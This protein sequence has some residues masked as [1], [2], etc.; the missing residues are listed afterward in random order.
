[1]KFRLFL[2]PYIQPFERVLAVRE[3]QAVLGRGVASQLNENE[4][5]CYCVE[6]QTA[7]DYLAERL[8]YWEK[9][10]AGNDEYLTNQVLL[11]A[12]ACVVLNG[13][14]LSDL[15][16]LVP[17]RNT[18]DVPVPRRRMLR[19][20]VHGL[21]EYR[22]KFFPQLVGAL[23]NIMNLQPGSIVLDPF[24]GSGTAPVEVAARGMT[25]LAMDLNPLSV[26]V[27]EAK[28][29]VFQIDKEKL[30]KAYVAVEEDIRTVGTSK[31]TARGLNSWFAS[32]P[33]VSRDYLAGWLAPTVVEDLDAI[34]SRLQQIEDCAVRR[35]FWVSLSNILRRVS[36]QKTDDL[37]VRRDIESAELEVVKT[38]LAELNRSVRHVYAFLS[39]YKG[40]SGPYEVRI[41]D[42]READ[43][44][45]SQYRGKVDAVITSPP[46]ATALPYIDTDRLSLAYLNLL[47][48]NQQKRLERVMIG[49]REISRGQTQKEWEHFLQSR[50]LLPEEVQE[51]I[52]RI[53]AANLKS[54]ASGF[55]RRN[56]PS[57]LAR[58]FLDMRQVFVSLAV[59]L[60]P[61]SPVCFV[62]G[63]NHTVIDGERI[64]IDTAALLARVAEKVGYEVE[65]ILPME[66]LISRDIFKAN[67]SQ[68]EALVFLKAPARKEKVNRPHA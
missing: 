62:V 58:Y 34:V 46:Y 36:W 19:Y 10:I 8:V 32:L 53:Y 64:E 3:L 49:T 20:G 5:S 66:M 37:R 35:L 13:T 38:Y 26:F 4:N 11:E 2:K 47:D 12:T 59:L 67:A 45:W 9:I 43:T 27:T 57:L 52:Q 33:A 23:I 60:R 1:M 61:A 18:N 44:V 22:G 7:A 48:R 31:A 56:L 55:R 17:F 29:G 25:A 39:Q 21:H 54:P 65:E 63:S 42:A 41:G 51:V 50:E 40:P 28:L 68:H 15:A 24:C 14:T 6:A 16:D 30:G